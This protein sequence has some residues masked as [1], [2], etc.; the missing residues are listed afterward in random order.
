MPS[1]VALPFAVAAVVLGRGD[2]IAGTRAT[3]VRANLAHTHLTGAHLG[4]TDLTDATFRGAVCPDGALATTAAC[5]DA[6]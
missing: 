3:F 2:R 1:R 5:A 6:G 4:H